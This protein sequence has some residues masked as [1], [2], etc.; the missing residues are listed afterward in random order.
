M[1]DIISLPQGN[2]AELCMRHAVDGM[3]AGRSVHHA[4]AACRSTCR[5]LCSARASGSGCCR[6][7]CGIHMTVAGLG[8]PWA[9]ADGLRVHASRRCPL[10]LSTMCSLGFHGAAVS[11]VWHVLHV[12]LLQ[13]TAGC[14]CGCSP[15]AGVSTECRWCGAAS[16]KSESSYE[17]GGGATS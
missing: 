9:P 11:I 5:M 14:T 8:R 17:G 2:T 13:Y 15:G 1:Y 12:L 7:P 10:Y 16:Y 6:D 3:C 4:H